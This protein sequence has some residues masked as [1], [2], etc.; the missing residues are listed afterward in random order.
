ML[1]ELLQ[2]RAALYVSGAMTAPER[3]NFELIL[4]FHDPLRAWVDNLKQL[5]F[6]VIVSRLGRTPAVDSSLKL[7]IMEAIPGHG[8]QLQPDGIVVTGPDCR[9]EWVNPA[10][11]AMCGYELNEIKGRK[12]G[13]FLQGPATDPASVNRI[14]EAL[15][16]RR[17]CREVLVNYHKSGSSYRVDVAISPILDDE[18]EPLWFIARE[19]ELPAS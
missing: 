16:K 14:R 8:R 7:R 12:P 11:T 3:E 18:G 2:N 5:E 19:R 17:A 13:H 6:A 1:T 15:E 4:E 9:I 10:F